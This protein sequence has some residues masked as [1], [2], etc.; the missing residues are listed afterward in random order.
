M[1]ITQEKKLSNYVMIMLKLY[2]R[3]FIEQSKEKD[4]K[5]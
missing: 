2:Q 3:L 5:Y 1:F 4:L